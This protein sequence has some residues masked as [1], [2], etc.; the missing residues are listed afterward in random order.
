M[1]DA[2]GKPCRLQDFACTHRDKWANPCWQENSCVPSLLCLPTKASECASWQYNQKRVEQNHL[3]CLRL[4]TSNCRKNCLPKCEH[5][6]ERTCARA[7]VRNQTQPHRCRS[8]LDDSTNPNHTEAGQACTTQPT[9]TTETMICLF[10]RH[11]NVR[12]HVH[13][14]VT[15]LNHTDAGQAWTTQPTPTTPRPV[16]PARLNQPQSLNQ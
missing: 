5:T 10:G 12:A 4:D 11:A 3:G 7:Y 2:E 1:P 15:K 6:H 9:P 16:K 13:T 8:S 14:Y